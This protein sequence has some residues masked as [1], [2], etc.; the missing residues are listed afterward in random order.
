MKFAF[1]FWTG[2]TSFELASLDNIIEDWK[3]LPKVH[4]L[5]RMHIADS[6]IHSGNLGFT[7]GLC[8]AQCNPGCTREKIV[9]YPFSETVQSTLGGLGT[10]QRWPHWGTRDQHSPTKIAGSWKGMYWRFP[11]NEALFCFRYFLNS[12]ASLSWTYR[13]L[14]PEC[15]F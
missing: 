5:L 6:F 1:D 9:W 13:A 8:S 10:D 14:Q 3:D 7:Y 11:T 4:A 12:L 15:I 2:Q